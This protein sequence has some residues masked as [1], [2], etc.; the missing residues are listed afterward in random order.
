MRIK[1]YLF[2]KLRVNQLLSIEPRLELQFLLLF[3]AL[4]LD[5]HLVQVDAAFL[6]LALNFRLLWQLGVFTADVGETLRDNLR[7]F[8]EAKVVRE[9]LKQSTFRGGTAQRIARR[10]LAKR[11]EFA[12][13]TKLATTSS[14]ARTLIA[15]PTVIAVF[16]IVAGSGLSSKD[17]GNE[18]YRNEKH[19]TVLIATDRKSVV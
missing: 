15:I 13:G 1:L 16:A 4:L 6:Q 9:V 14:L 5:L 8:V 11:T 17:E 12:V 10:N 19:T 3:L 18:N 2:T 7:D